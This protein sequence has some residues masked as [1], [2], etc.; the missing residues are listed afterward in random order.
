[1]DILDWIYDPAY[2][3]CAG[4]FKEGNGVIVEWVNWVYELIE[5]IGLIGFNPL[6]QS[7]HQPFNES[8]MSEF[9]GL[10]SNPVN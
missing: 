8:T 5:L 4:L 6:D 7:T 3:R 2:R 1:M 9:S 10:S